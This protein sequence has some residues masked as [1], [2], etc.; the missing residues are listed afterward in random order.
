MPSL[1][2]PDEAKGL[3]R[4]ETRGLASPCHL[5]ERNR[6]A[7]VELRRSRRARPVVVLPAHGPTLPCESVLMSQMSC[8]PAP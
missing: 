3:S 5:G 4:L 7:S 8:P 1:G 6:V 2:E